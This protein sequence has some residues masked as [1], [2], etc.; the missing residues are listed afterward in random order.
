MQDTVTDTTRAAAPTPS[1][2]LTLWD[3]LALA[4]PIMLANA[5][6]PLIGF[7]DAA[8]IGQLGN[9]ALIGG[10]AVGA[11]IFNA[12]YWCVGFLRMST[13][14][15]TAQAYGARDSTEIAATLLRALLIAGVIGIAVVVFQAPIRRALLWFLGGSPAVQ[16]AATEYYD[17]RIWAAPAGLANV[18]LLGWFIG[19]GRTMVAFCVQV[20][21][22]VLNIVFALA[23]V[24]WLGWGVSAVGLAAFLSEIAAVAGGFYYARREL[25]AHGAGASRATLLDGAKLRALFAANRDIMIRTVCVLAVGQIF[26]R[27]GATQGDA[28]LAANALLASI[29]M[30]TY[31]LLDGYG[32]A[33]ETLIGQAVGA[34]D[35][36][37]LDL[38][39]R[40]ASIA[41]AITG[42][43]I[44]VVLWFTAGPIIAFMTTNTEVQAHAAA[45]FAWVAWLPLIAVG[46]FL[47]D[48]VFIGATRTVDMRNMMLV[49]FVVYLGVLAIA[50]PWLGNHGLWLAQAVFFIARAVTLAW[51][52]PALAVTADR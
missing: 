49:S 16:A 25:A 11:A 34:R 44:G 51:K 45:Y 36:P 29:L 50:L 31:F 10:V 17:W 23:F 26:I 14:G 21:A 5:S 3:V 7:V 22:N 6:T 35:R 4:A 2:M 1:P 38:S 52:Y 12:I 46:C 32:H 39:V 41:A 9:A 48:G 18:A 30:I 27:F 37:R 24:S 42:A 19:L 20:L 40:L 33:T 28:V 8:V 15:F 43:F 47:L 13:T